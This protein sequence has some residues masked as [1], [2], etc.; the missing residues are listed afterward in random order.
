MGNGNGGDFEE[1]AQC[2]ATGREQRTAQ[3]LNC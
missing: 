1:G 2:E 3:I